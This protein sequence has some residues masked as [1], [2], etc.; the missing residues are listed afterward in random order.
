MV[1][2][3][4]SIRWKFWKLISSDKVKT[5]SEYFMSEPNFTSK[6]EIISV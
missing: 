2:N 3:V 6:K 1:E 4:D 5:G